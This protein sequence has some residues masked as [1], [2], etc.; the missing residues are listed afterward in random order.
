MSQTIQF[1]Y[2]ILLKM[3]IFRKMEKYHFFGFKKKIFDSLRKTIL[4]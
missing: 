3:T 4:S 2:Q 1:L